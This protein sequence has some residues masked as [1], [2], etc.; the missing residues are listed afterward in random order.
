MQ[1]LLQAL[2]ELGSDAVMVVH[3]A[4]GLDELSPQGETRLAELRDGRIV[5]RLVTPEDAGLSRHALKEIRG[6]DAAANLEILTEVLDGRRRDA[7]RQSRF[8]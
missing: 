1:Q 3:G 6:G 5:E 2:R 7:V 4:D 8:G